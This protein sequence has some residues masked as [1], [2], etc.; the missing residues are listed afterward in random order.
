[1]L[2]QCYPDILDLISETRDYDGIATVIKH[3]WFL[4]KPKANNINML[5][6]FDKQILDNGQSTLINQKLKMDIM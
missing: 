1:M 4:K 5:F 6:S 2:S 3:W